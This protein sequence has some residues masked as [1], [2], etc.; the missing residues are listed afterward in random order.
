MLIILNIL[1]FVEIGLPGD[2]GYRGP[3]GFEGPKGFKGKLF[4]N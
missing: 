4:L 3:I 2:P 1:K